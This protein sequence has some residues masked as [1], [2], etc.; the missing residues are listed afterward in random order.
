MTGNRWRILRIYVTCDTNYFRSHIFCH[1]RFCLV[2][3]TAGI[4]IPG[5]CIYPWNN[6]YHGNW[7]IDP[8][9]ES[10]K[11]SILS[12]TNL[13]FSR[14]MHIYNSL[15]PSLI[16]IIGFQCPSWIYAA[17]LCHTFLWQ[18]QKCVKKFRCGIKQLGN[19]G[20]VN[21]GAQTQHLY[22]LLG[23]L[24]IHFFGPCNRKE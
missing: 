10:A 5:I 9:S 13:P 7:F 2:H 18:I 4:C 23:V 22:S 6:L 17:G 20:W 24:D 14:H 12:G 3:P 1:K 16:F 8:K 11:M 21:V 15:F 19:V